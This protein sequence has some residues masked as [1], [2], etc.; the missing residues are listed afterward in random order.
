MLVDCDICLQSK[1]CIQPNPESVNFP[2]LKSFTVC[3]DGATL[4]P[5]LNLLT[6]PS[7]ESLTVKGGSQTPWPQE[8]VLRLIHRSSCRLR[9]LALEENA[10]PVEFLVPLMKATPDVVSFITDLDGPVTRTM[11]ETMKSENLLL[12]SG[13]GKSDSGILKEP[14]IRGHLS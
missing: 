12:R 6:L 5:L 11:L 13:F 8:E 1:Q 3:P 14:M 9:H 10:M 7:L 4:G 2:A